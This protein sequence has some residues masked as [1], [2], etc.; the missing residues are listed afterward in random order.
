MLPKLAAAVCITTQGISQ[1]HRTAL[2]NLF[3]IRMANGTNVINA[4][5][6]V[7][8]IDKKKQRSTRIITIPEILCTLFNR[9]CAI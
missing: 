1:W 5:S 3:K 8:T 6:F 9:L 4:T 7:I 2:G